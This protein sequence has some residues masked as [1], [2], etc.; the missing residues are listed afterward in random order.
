MSNSRYDRLLI[1]WMYRAGLSA[2][3]ICDVHESVTSYRANDSYVRNII[4][5]LS[6]QGLR[7]DGTTYA[8]AC[9]GYLRDR[10]PDQV[11][12][13]IIFPSEVAMEGHRSKSDKSPARVVNTNN[14]LRQLGVFEN[15]ERPAKAIRKINPVEAEHL[16]L[17]NEGLAV[18]DLVKAEAH[19]C[20]ELIQQIRKAHQEHPELVDKHVLTMLSSTANDLYKLLHQAS[21]LDRR[22]IEIRRGVYGLDEQEAAVDSGVKIQ[23]VEIHIHPTRQESLVDTVETPWVDAQFQE[24]APVE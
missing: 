6:G 7:R 3:S 17:A 24:E 11:P 16:Q 9:E 20:I 21:D 4:S 10:Y 15:G 23:K 14:A 22:Y 13:R 12:P 1:S 19:A 2:N 18:A 5:S 8:E